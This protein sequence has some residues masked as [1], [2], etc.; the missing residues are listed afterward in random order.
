MDKIDAAKQRQ[1]HFCVQIP[2]RHARPDGPRANTP[3]LRHG[4]S[5]S[6]RL[7]IGNANRFHITCSLCRLQRFCRPFQLRTKA[8]NRGM[9][10]S[11]ISPRSFA[12]RRRHNAQ[13][14][15]SGFNRRTAERLNVSIRISYRNQRS[16]NAIANRYR[17]FLFL[18]AATI[19]PAAHCGN[20]VRCRRRRRHDAGVALCR[21]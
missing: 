3:K 21:F 17:V 14:V 7:L 13:S 9:D 16:M 11:F 5:W 18:T 6:L 12:L 4:V 2:D 1:C 10:L 15:S 19:Q 8:Q 20:K